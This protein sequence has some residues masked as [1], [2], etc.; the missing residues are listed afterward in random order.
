[1]GEGVGEAVVVGEED[2]VLEDD[3]S[4]WV[5]PLQPASTNEPSASEATTSDAAEGTDVSDAS[6]AAL[7]AALR[8]AG[9]FVT[10]ALCP[11]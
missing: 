7:R 5:S 11:I 2:E 4:G 9:V 3:A 8:A 10:D 1:M 6:A